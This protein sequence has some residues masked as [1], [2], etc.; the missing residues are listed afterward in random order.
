[1]RA[2]SAS[3]FAALLL[4]SLPAT[5]SSLPPLTASLGVGA[6]VVT[7]RAYDMVDDNDHLPMIHVGAGYRFQLA[8]GG[9]ELEL[10]YQGGSTSAP[11]HAGADAKLWLRGLEL[12]ATYRYPLWRFCE[13]YARLGLGVDW[14]TLSLDG[15][16]LTQRVSVPSGS[17]MV[18]FSVP[19][20]TTKA[21]AGRRALVAIELGL[22]YA[23]RRAADFNAL[24]PEPPGKVSPDAMGQTGIDMG[25]LFL[26]GITYR[27]GLIAR[28]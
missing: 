13:P 24:A 27:V 3:C 16:A 8:G 25:K 1:M 2:L 6:Q 22:G 7:D 28:L 9:L 18:G 14:A 10:G 5:A 23:L 4:Q 26:S 15:D 20:V 11:L 17:A 19:L 12:S 21:E